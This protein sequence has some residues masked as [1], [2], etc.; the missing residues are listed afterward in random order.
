MTKKIT[1]RD[2]QIY[3]LKKDG[4]TFA[5]IANLFDISNARTQKIYTEVKYLKE[6][7]EALY[8]LGYIDYDDPWLENHRDKNIAIFYIS[9]T[10]RIIYNHNI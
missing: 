3:Q 5:Y 7:T 9:P 2:E 1:K 6:I 10:R 8:Q 4:H